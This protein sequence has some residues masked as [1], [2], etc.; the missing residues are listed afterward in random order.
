[1]NTRMRTLALLAIATAAAACRGPNLVRLVGS[2]RLTEGCSTA[3][4]IAQ[5]PVPNGSSAS[6]GNDRLYRVA[7]VA[8]QPGVLVVCDS[9]DQNCSA[10]PGATH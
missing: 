5:V 1:M 7:C 3:P 9:M 4:S 10:P 6:S 2:L 8:N